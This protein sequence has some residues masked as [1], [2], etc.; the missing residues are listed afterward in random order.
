MDEN[1]DGQDEKRGEKIH[2]GS[3][4]HLKKKKKK[5]KDNKQIKDGVHMLS[6]KDFG[7]D[8]LI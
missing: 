7:G 8:L 4:H 1:G 5:K 2:K 3:K 6:N